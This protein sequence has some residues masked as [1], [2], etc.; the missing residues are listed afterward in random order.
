MQICN[1]FTVLWWISGF[2]KGL[3]RSRLC[4]TVSTQ[5]SMRL[6]QTPSIKLRRD[7]HSRLPHK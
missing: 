3:V 4:R 5:V 7:L 2:R 6:P 1:I